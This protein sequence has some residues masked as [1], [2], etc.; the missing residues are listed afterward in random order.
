M[1]S[2]SQDD[3][4]ADVQPTS[5]PP[6][7]GLSRLLALSRRGKGLLALGI[8]L[9]CVGSLLQLVPYLAAWQVIASLLEGVAHGHAFDAGTMAWWGG[10]GL[11]GLL[12]GAA[13]SYFSNLATHV[14]AYRA[15]CDIRI[16]VAEHVGH[17]PMGR[18]DSSSIGQVEQ[19][20][21]ADV[22]QVETFLAHQVPDFASTLVTLV[23]LF[24]VMFF[25]N[26]WLAL[27]CLV[28][29][30]IGI[31]C[32][33]LAMVKVMRSGAAKKNFDVLERINSSI[34]Q[35]VEGMPAIKVFGQTAASFRSFRD[36]V[37]AYRDFTTGMTDQIRT[38]YVGFRVFTLSVATFAAPVAIALF[39]DNPT[40]VALV[41]VCVFFLVVGPAASSP[42][43]KLRM[44]AEG[45]NVVNEAVGR[46]CS[47]L[48]LEAQEQAPQR[49]QDAPRDAGISFDHV[50]FAYP[51]AERPTLDDVSFSVRPGS[52]CAIVG[53]SGAGKSTVA[54]MVGRFWDADEGAVSIGGTDIRRLGTDVLMGSISFVFQDSFLFEGTIR[55][56][57]ALGRPDAT[58]EQVIAAASAAQCDGFLSRLPDGIDTMV[59]TAGTRL[60]G[61][62]RQRVAIARAILKDAPILVLDEASSF[63]DAQTQLLVQRALGRLARG[64]TVLMVAHRLETVCSADQILV[65]DGGKVVQEGTH[66]ELIEAD[67]P[68]SKMWE[69]ASRVAE[70]RIGTEGATL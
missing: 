49:Y 58:D 44:F 16:A 35:Y 62:E 41:A 11:A 10:V 23:A 26:V 8:A 50:T 46:V 42:V 59:G 37:E 19:V 25:A 7:T 70:W 63:A 29:I 3:L 51:G 60:S 52:T 15:V 54:E 22:E 4:A 65:M 56:N 34:V 40:D 31:A 33:M 18:L 68:Y 69:A 45:V 14:Y 48:D 53:P 57:I 47:L 24:A 64:K 66:D 32:Q 55:D 27:A 36:D 9:G 17:L 43:L 39:L 2:T 20:M 12:A 1:K 61:G 13:V 30:A 67:G 28:P 5:D 21:D 38:G 6:N